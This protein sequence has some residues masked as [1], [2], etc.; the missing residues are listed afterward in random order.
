M[1]NPN[2]KKID[3]KCI[4]SVRSRVMGLR[5]LLD[6]P[7][8]HMTIDQFKDEVICRLMGIDSID[9]AKRYQLTEEDWTA[10]EA[11]ADSKYRNW[12]WNYGNSPRYSYNRDAHLGIGTVE[13]SLEV[14]AG[15]ISKCRIYGDFFGKGAIQ[16]IEEALLGT[17]VTKQDLLAVLSK[18]DLAHYFGPVS[19]QELVDLILS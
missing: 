11:L 8:R 16:D 2:R 12:E 10:I 15:R 9:Q 5:E 14:E 7:Y 19:A 18:Q 1:L 17:P 3:S 13:F 6:E 4:K